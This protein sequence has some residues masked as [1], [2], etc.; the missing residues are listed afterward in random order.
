MRTGWA[1]HPGQ[2]KAPGRL[3]CNLAFKEGGVAKKR[4]R[5]YFTQAQSDRTRESSF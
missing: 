2:E 5:D 4:E 3:H 1:V